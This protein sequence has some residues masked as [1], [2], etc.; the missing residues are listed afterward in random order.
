[1]KWRLVGRVGAAVWLAAAMAVAQPAV[2]SLEQQHQRGIELLRRG[3]NDQALTVFRGIYERTREPRALWRMATAEAALGRWVEAEGHMS[4]AFASSSDTW[5]SAQRASLESTLR[6]VQ[7]RVG[8]LTVHSNVPGATITVDGQAVTTFPLRVVAG[9]VRV[10]VRADGYQSAEL[11]VSVPGN[12]D[13]P[14]V[15]EVELQPEAAAR[16]AS[17]V[18]Q[19]EIAVSA[20]ATTPEVPR[21]GPG[22]GPWILVGASGALAAVGGVMFVLAGNAQSDRDAATAQQPAQDADARLRTYAYTG[23]G[24]MGAALIG[25][26]SGLIWGLVGHRSGDA[27][28]A[29]APVPG[30]AVVGI[31]GA[32]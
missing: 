27:R 20:G 8:L 10:A 26:V 19:T 18:A 11:T 21:R 3:Q 7:A 29:V 12:V 25:G 31:G 17:T 6:Q 5:I 15:R 16:P 9:D 32:L 13:H 23:D 30:G 14:F 28:V 1:M 22:A 24:L 2:G 4:A